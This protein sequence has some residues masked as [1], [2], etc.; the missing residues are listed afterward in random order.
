MKNSYEKRNSARTQRANTVSTYK[1]AYQLIVKDGLDGCILDFGAG[2]GLGSQELGGSCFTYE[3]F[4]QDWK[5]VFDS[6]KAI[7][8]AGIDFDAIVSLNVLNVLTPECRQEAI[9]DIVSFLKPSGKA[10]ISVRPT[11][12]VESAK[13]KE[14]YLDGFLV[15]NSEKT[16]QKGFKTSELVNYCQLLLGRNYIVKPI[17][18]G[19]VGVSIERVR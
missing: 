10:Y 15:G 2:L 14:P 19:K 13:V 8:Q 6:I 12:D 17:R 18:L 1:R 3:P 11:A 4:A 7:S 5:P 9:F 16:F